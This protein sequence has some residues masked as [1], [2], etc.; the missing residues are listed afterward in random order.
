MRILRTALVGLSLALGLGCAGTAEMLGDLAGLDL[1][2]KLGEAAV[3][4]A[5][6][7]AAP[8]VGGKKQMSMA[9][10][11]S[12]EAV[13]LPDGVE[14]E[15]EEGAS[16]RTELIT[17]QLAPADVDAAV[18]TARTEVETAG[19][20][21]AEVEASPDDAEVHLYA[22]D[23]ALFLVLGGAEEDDDEGVLVLMRLQPS[24][25]PANE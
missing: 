23:Q 20:T 15:L 12:S 24:E 14:I 4:P 21:T 18:A 6:F 19:W 8:P 22:D 25:E 7:P 5:D 2:M 10:T 9:L 11:T 1:Q 17:Y 3:H 16:Y 13:N